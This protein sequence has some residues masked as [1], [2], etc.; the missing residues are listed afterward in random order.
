MT[1]FSFDGTSYQQEQDFFLLRVGAPEV[2][3][4]GLD[5]E[6]AA[7]VDGHRWWSVAE[8]EATTESFY[9]RELPRLLR[10]LTGPGGQS[11]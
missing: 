1:S 7:V 11:A 4:D 9:P 2:T 6:E 8:L 10:D 3:T 5:D